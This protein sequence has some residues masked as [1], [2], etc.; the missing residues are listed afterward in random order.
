MAWPDREELPPAARATS[1]HAPVFRCRSC[2]HT[3]HRTRFGLFAGAFVGNSLQAG[4]SEQAP[5]RAGA[6]TAVLGTA[7]L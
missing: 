1:S 3:G 6:R 2:R 4:P 5:S 7:R